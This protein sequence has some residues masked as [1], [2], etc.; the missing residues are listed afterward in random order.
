MITLEVRGTARALRIDDDENRFDRESIDTLHSA[1]DET[2]AQGP[3]R[4]NG[5]GQGNRD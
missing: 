1:V 4:I 2:P 5:P 3:E